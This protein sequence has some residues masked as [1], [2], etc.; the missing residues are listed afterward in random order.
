M[1]QHTPGGGH[2]S[3]A[4]VSPETT[5]DPHNPAGR[6]TF[7]GQPGMLANLFSVEM[8]ERF[9]FYGMQALVLYYMYYAVSDGGL[10]LDEGVAAGIVGAYGG[11]VYLCSILGGWVAD[12]LLG[13]ERTMLT[14]AVLIM[15]GHI[16]LAL[17]PGVAGLTVGLLCIAVGSGGLKTTCVNLVGTLYEREDPRRDAG[18][19]IYYMGVNIGAL[20]G[21]LLTSFAW[22]T[23]GFHAGFGIAAIF[24]ALGL[25][26]YLLTRKGL[27][28]TVHTVANPLPRSQ[29]GKWI[30]IA[31]AFIAVVVVLLLTGILNP[32]NL[33]DAV[34]L[35]V[36]V[37]AVVLFAT[38]LRD[39]G[40]SA[41][42]HSRVVAFI[43]LFIATAAFFALFQ[44]QFTVLAIYADTRLQLSIFG[45]DFKP[46]ATQSI[47]PVFIILMGMV[48]AAVWTK[49]G[50]RQPSTPVK[51]GIALLL[52]GVAFLLFITQAHTESVFVGWIVLVLFFA[53]L[54]ELFLSPVGLSLATKLAPRRYPVQMVA[55]YNLSIALGTA[56]S[57]S[58]AEFYSRENEVGYFGTMGAITIVLGVVMLLVAKPILKL[59]RGIR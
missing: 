34:I 27:P 15:F 49:L 33:S 54:G 47:N 58:L 22:G 7:F 5:V 43:P 35:V 21:P 4:P 38:M 41:D 9:S 51:F 11:T 12:R 52:I 20:F 29:Y 55:L 14:S 30:G 28:D 40:L 25:V 39:K 16:A 19:S 48:F 31:L 24:M 23:W 56:L 6:K 18:F 13:S 1:S 8:W 2:T 36:V 3:G 42:E 46:S 50:T 32:G 45:I 10:G 44:Q 57:G 17:I 59:M 37:A 53:T 26:Q